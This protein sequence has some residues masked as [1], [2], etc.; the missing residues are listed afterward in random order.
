MAT[1]DGSILN[2]GLPTISTDLGCPVDVV[3]WVVLS[4]SLTL[5]S[6]LLVFGVWSGVKGYSFAY[7]LGYSLFIIGSA[8]CA[9]AA[10]IYILV[11]GRVVQASGSAMFA[12]VGPGMVTQ[13]FPA[14]ERGKGIGMM[15]MMVSAGFMV[16]APLGGLIL[17]FWP[18]QALFMINVPIGLIGLL[19]TR[20]YFKSVPPTAP[21]ARLPLKGAVAASLG[22]L[23][24]TLCLSLINDFPLTDYRVWGLVLVSG[25][26][27]LAFLKFESDPDTALIGLDIFKNWQFT[28]SIG[29]MLMMFMANSGVLILVPFYLERIKNFEPKQ[30]GFYLIIL[31][32][33]MFIF[34]PLSG[35]LSDR[36]GYRFLTVLGVMIVMSGLYLLT[37]LSAQTT[38]NHIVL[39]LVVLG[40]GIGIFNTP[41]SSALMGSVRSDQRAVTSSILATTR[42]I[43]MSTGVALSTALFAYFQMKNSELGSPTEAFVGS[44]RNVISVSIVIAAGS[45]MFS[46]L[47]GRRAIRD[48]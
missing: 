10:N 12:A 22:L 40:A 3:A 21:D 39:S 38:N 27:L 37:D 33:L 18:W 32:V 14:S 26:C 16:G 48:D 29:A 4:Y 15:V 5:I 44:Y 30:V 6:L 13:V 42:N 41:N 17:D 2:V 8:V 31:P 9:S 28:S 43:G 24:G 35:R 47:R 11:V 46:V 7:K 45:L 36:I 23:S 20:A 25:L 19:M 1:L 34:S